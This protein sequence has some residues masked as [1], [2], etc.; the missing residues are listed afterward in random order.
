MARPKQAERWHV[1]AITALPLRHG[2]IYPVAATAEESLAAMFKALDIQR[3]T[4]APIV[5]ALA[6]GGSLEVV[7]PSTHALPAW[8]MGELVRSAT[9]D[10]VRLRV[11]GPG[12]SFEYV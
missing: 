2:A 5:A 12:G 1:F 9:S 4:S 7:G 6:P 8:V 3:D 10:G 11:A